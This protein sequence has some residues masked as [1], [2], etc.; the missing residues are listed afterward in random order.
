MGSDVATYVL[1][2]DLSVL[3]NFV[4]M[5]EETCVFTLNVSDSLEE[6]AYLV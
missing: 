3:G 1:V 4:S 5:Y 6:V 2:G